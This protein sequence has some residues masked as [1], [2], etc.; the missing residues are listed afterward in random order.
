MGQASYFERLVMLRF[1]IRD[2]LWLMV[3]MALG[4]SWWA[5]RTRV[6]NSKAIAVNDARYILEVLTD[7][8]ADYMPDDKR[9]ELQARYF[10]G[11]DT[12]HWNV[13]HQATSN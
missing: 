11:L 10:P 6:L 9:L 13:K 3:V 7:P 8:F 12:R 1:S 4:L 5:D 2:V